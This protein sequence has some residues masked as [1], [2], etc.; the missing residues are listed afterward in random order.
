[1][2]THDS[3]FRTIARAGSI[4]LVVLGATVLV[5][6]LFDLGLLKSILPGHISM[7]VNT[8]IGFVCSGAALSLSLRANSPSSRKLRYPIAFLSLITLVIGF[9]SLA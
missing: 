2:H 6:W 1:M 5:G 8:A 4:F 3:Q 7:K 9:F